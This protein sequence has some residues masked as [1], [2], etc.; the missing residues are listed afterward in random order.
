MAGLSSREAPCQRSLIVFFYLK[1]FKAN[2]WQVRFP[3]NCITYHYLLFCSWKCI[4]DIIIR[5][6]VEHVTLHT[7][8]FQCRQTATI[9]RPSYGY[10]M[11][12]LLMQYDWMSVHPIILKPLSTWIHIP[13]AIETFGKVL[14]SSSL[15]INVMEQPSQE[16]LHTFILPLQP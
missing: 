5:N 8:K 1:R 2:H 11:C 12:S 6:F 13:N 16:N 3:A 9:V 14:Y 15:R 7:Q 4:S 10:V